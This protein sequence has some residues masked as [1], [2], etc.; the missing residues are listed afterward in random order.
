M[1]LIRSNTSGGPC[2][3]LRLAFISQVVALS[4]FREFPGLPFLKLLYLRFGLK[5]IV[6]VFLRVPRLLFLSEVVVVLLDFRR[7][8]LPRLGYYFGCLCSYRTGLIF[9]FRLLS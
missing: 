2:R 5:L 9:R 7:L 3:Q 8:I 1:H 6:G 4:L